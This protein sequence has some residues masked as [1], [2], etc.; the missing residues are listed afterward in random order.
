MI[1]V[2]ERMY[3]LCPGALCY[4]CLGINT[5]LTSAFN[6]NVHLISWASDVK[7]CWE[8]SKKEIF[9]KKKREN[10]LSENMSKE[11]KH[12]SLNAAAG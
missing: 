12:S 2:C 3:L 4:N 9:C 7:C 6:I 5:D 10:V 11:C 8:D 1:D